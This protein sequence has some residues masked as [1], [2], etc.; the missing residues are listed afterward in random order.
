M[1]MNELMKGERKFCF[2]YELS[3]W[4]ESN[5]KNERHKKTFRETVWSVEDSRV[6]A[7]KFQRQSINGSSERFC[8]KH[9]E[10]ISVS[11]FR[12]IPVICLI[13]VQNAM[14]V[15]VNILTP[16]L[17]RFSVGF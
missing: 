17:K 8:N 15:F 10:F 11:A 12:S 5:V 2:E 4:N 16:C 7:K 1:R 9:K 6:C 3:G 14:K 13:C